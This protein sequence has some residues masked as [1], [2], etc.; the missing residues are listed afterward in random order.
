MIKKIFFIIGLFI[1]VITSAWAADAIKTEQPQLANIRTPTFDNTPLSLST[2]QKKT[3]PI[4]LNF[5]SIKVRELLQII[6][7]FTRLNFVIN[8]SVKGD[9]SIHLHDVPWTQALDVILK[10]QDLGERSVG[11][12][13]YVAP[14]ADLV[15]QQIAELEANQRVRDLV[16]LEDRVIHLNYADATEMQKILDTKNYSLLSARGSTNVDTRTN[17]VWIRDTPE[18]VKTITKL[19]K[20]LDFPV[21][22]VMIEA[23][24][25]SVDEGFERELG[26]RF[27]LSKP[28]YLSGTLAGANAMAGSTA[29][30]ASAVVAGV[31][32]FT[33]RL[34]FNL[35]ATGGGSVLS[36]STPGSIGL[37]VAKM[38]ATFID[39]E[40]SALEE[41]KDL[42]IISSPQLITSNQQKAY[43]QTGEEIPYQS[44]TSSGAT[45][46]SFVNAVLKL[47]VTPQI[48]PD[49][50]IILNL[51]VTN[52]SAGATIA[53]SGG[54][55]AVPIDTEEEGS[56]VL[57]NDNQTVVLGGVYKRTK[58]NTV[59]RI[60][61]LG[62]IPLLGNLF[63]HTDKTTINTEL[64]IF[65]T[66]HIIHKPS[67]IS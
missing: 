56:R 7:Q 37:A 39:M 23:R 9:M 41:Q 28:G 31:S 32:P 26:A 45:A 50:R 60:P 65:L 20:Q 18:H 52:N 8:D 6:A 55:S 47:E 49:N 67:D 40:L 61:F 12:I 59:Q 30:G 36:G 3:E 44:A 42:D 21:E 25:V 22:Q 14:V 46:V 13:V 11:K 43:I 5:T 62:R 1:V 15:K 17:S 4:S 48:T 53:L 64:L 27:G 51:V 24:I 57:L 29:S 34:N 33:N 35:P 2:G 10:S 58:G 66:P 16:P 38:G 63:K 19:V 54:G